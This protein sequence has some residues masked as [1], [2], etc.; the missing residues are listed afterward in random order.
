MDNVTSASN[1]P[2]GY[3]YVG[4]NDNDILT[5]MGVQATYSTQS[6][7]NA[8]VGF[9]GGDDKGAHGSGIPGATVTGTS[10][11]L[12][13]KTDVSYNLKN[14]TEN[15]KY[16]KT[17]EGVTVSANVSVRSSSSDADLNPTSGGNLFVVNG[18]KEYSRSLQ[19]PSG[20]LVYPSGTTPSTASVKIPA[21]EI[22][23]TSYLQSGAVRIGLT[24]QNTVFSLPI[25]IQWGL[26]IKPTYRQS[27]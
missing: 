22:S 13:I 17:F 21:S 14:V 6:N 19:T 24:N 23:S 27:K 15:N 12:S 25:K 9:V 3:A 10:A 8:G 2:E 1:T 20:N 7:T 4:A 18:N 26:Q 11:N 16:G 5:D